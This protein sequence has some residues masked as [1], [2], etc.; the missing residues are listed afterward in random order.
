VAL[1]STSIIMFA[2]VFMVAFV[3]SLIGLME[4]AGS[5]EKKKA[6]YIGLIT[7]ILAAIIWMVFSLIW[8]ASSTVAMFVPFGY[9]WTALT[10]TFTAISLASGG[11]I[12]RYSVKPEQKDME[13]RER[14]D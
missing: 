13:I 6:S 9:L 14:I 8:T 7:S 2:M 1:D 12:L 10:V 5:L 11:L 4:F 3:F